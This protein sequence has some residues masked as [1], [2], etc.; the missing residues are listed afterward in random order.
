MR[1][2]PYPH[3]RNTLGEPSKA[4]AEGFISHSLNH[5]KMKD[6]AKLVIRELTD[7]SPHALLLGMGATFFILGY[8][9]H[10]FYSIV[11][12]SAFV[13]IFIAV[14]VQL[15]RFAAGLA[16]ANFFKHQRYFLGLLVMGLSLWL[17]YFEHGEVEHIAEAV[18]TAYPD[19]TR[20]ILKLIVW[21][22]PILELFLG[23]TLGVTT[24]GAK[25]R[26]DQDH[27]DQE[28]PARYQREE[29]AEGAYTGNGISRKAASNGNGKN[30]L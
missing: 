5:Q 3:K 20:D 1:A 16:S 15:L 11:F 8:L 13:A 7:Y 24:T 27:G 22:G 23:L 9:Q 14:I 10:A 6:S 12:E 25:D 29:I 18:A 21:V 26:S 19:A 2:I 17:T 4:S 28:R 30:P